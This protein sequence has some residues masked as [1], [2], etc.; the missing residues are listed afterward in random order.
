VTKGTL[1]GAKRPPTR[2]QLSRPRASAPCRHPVPWAWRHPDRRK[3]P[4]P[5]ARTRVVAHC[6]IRRRTI[7]LGIAPGRTLALAPAGHEISAS[8]ADLVRHRSTSRTAHQAVAHHPCRRTAHDPALAAGRAGHRALQTRCGATR[9]LPSDGRPTGWQFRP[10]EAERTMAVRT[11]Q[12]D[13]L[14]R[15]NATDGPVHE[16]SPEGRWQRCGLEALSRPHRL[17]ADGR[18][19]PCA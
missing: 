8:E 5:A 15:S 12:R 2:Q 3:D 1:G 18:W 17:H 7:R 10:G 14:S 4:L 13:R 11:H 9:C 6:R 16:R 19:Q